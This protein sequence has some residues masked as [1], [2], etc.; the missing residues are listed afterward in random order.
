[1]VEGRPWASNAL[2]WR[3]RL[4]VQVNCRNKHITVR[5]ERAAFSKAQKCSFSM[6]GVLLQGLEYFQINHR[7]H[8]S[9]FWLLS[10]LIAQ[11]ELSSH[12]LM[13]WA[14]F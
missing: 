8:A 4:D 14:P 7:Q 11:R 6:E 1:M 12:L 10:R 3:L 5:G 13:T 2:D 9:L